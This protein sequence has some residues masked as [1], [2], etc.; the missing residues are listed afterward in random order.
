MASSTETAGMA[1]L[2]GLV[3]GC[4]GEQG[5]A[6]DSGSPTAGCEDTVWSWQSVGEPFSRTWCTSCHHSD[7]PVEA[8]QGA[9]AEV[10][11][12][13]HAGFVAWAGEIED[14]VWSADQPMPPVGVPPEDEL[15]AL[16]AWLAC[17]AP[18]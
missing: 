4:A 2:L 3:V 16:E 13:T 7:L 12:E 11:L 10:N 9:P 17:G 8:R 15:A 1:A 18:E 5:G 6:G 14:R